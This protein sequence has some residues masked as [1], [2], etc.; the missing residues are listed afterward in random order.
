MKISPLLTQFS[1]TYFSVDCGMAYLIRLSDGRFAVIDSAYGEYDEPDRLYSLMCEQ[2][3]TEDMPRVAAW[4][5]THPHGDHINGF[6][7]MSRKYLDKIAVE[8]VYFDFPPYSVSSATCDMP[9]FLGAIEAFGAKTV[10]PRRGDVIELASEK[11]EVLYTASDWQKEFT[12]VNDASLVMKIHLGN[13]TFMS[14]G[15]LMERSARVLMSHHSPEVLKC[16]IMQMA[17]HGY[18]G[19]CTDFF[20][21]VDPEIVLWPMPEFRYLDILELDHNR[22]FKYMDNRIRHIF[23]SGIEENTFDMTKPIEI[24]VPYKPIKIVTDFSKKS[25]SALGWSCFTGGHMGYAPAKL[26]FKDSS[27][28]LRSHNSRTLLQLIQRGQVAVSDGY[29]LSLTLIPRENCELLG[30]IYDCPAL[31]TPDLFTVRHIPHKAG[32]RIDVTLT[33]DRASGSAALV[34]GGASERLSLES[35]EPCD[36]VLIMKNATVTIEKV[37]FENI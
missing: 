5:F 34:I 12:N 32:E 3:V 7:N 35:A 15:D 4:F 16:D 19:G 17:H 37:E 25:V 6:I 24:T 14:V 1:P 29:R 22:Y 30:L 13:Y 18:W 36:A 26:E 20:A 2:N 21:T 10:S 23:F 9:A 33:V 31:T 28:T 11:F 27:A 8:R